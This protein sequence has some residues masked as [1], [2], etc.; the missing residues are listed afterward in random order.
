MTRTEDAAILVLNAGSSSVK[1]ALFRADT[2]EPL[3][4][5]GIEGIGSAARFGGAAGA[6]AHLFDGAVLPEGSRHE[7]ATHWLLDR[8]RCADHLDLRAA[9]HRVVHGGPDFS[10][11]VV[12]DDDV[13]TSLEG[14]IPLAPA[15][16]PHNLAA[17]RAV[18]KAWPDLPQLACF[19]TAFHRSMPRLAQL[20]AIPHA[21]TDQGL[22]RYGFHGLSYQHIADVLPDIAGD[23]AQGRVIV[24]HLGHGA[25]LC[26]MREG[27]SIATTMGFTALDGLMMGMRCGAI[28][29]G[30]VLY[31]IEQRGMTPAEVSEILNRRSGLLGV[32]GISNDARTLLASEEPRATEALDLFAYR[33]VR[34]AGSMMAALGGLDAF[35][36]TAGIG[37]R[38]ARIRSA[39]AQGLAWTGIR[40]DEDRNA[41]NTVR[42]SADGATI[43]VYVIPADEE[44]PIARS[45]G[46]QVLSA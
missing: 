18:A 23:V 32:S 10:A 5:G 12:I 7:A 4:R 9:G 34:E 42:I 31:L 29:A 44:L 17:I 11:P 2:L 3:C 25:S 37:E 46:S 41:A 13:M 20:F 38:S 22:I 24:A 36:F 30:L 28:D 33:V 14:L 40:L 39:I 27:R 43:P 35:V 19:D 6:K 8:L 15:H 16:Q 21:L 1:F 26:A 45:V